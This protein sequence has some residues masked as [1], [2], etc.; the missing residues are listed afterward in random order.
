LKTDSIL[1]GINWEQN[2]TACLMINGEVIACVSEERFSRVKN[3]ERYPINAINWILKHYNINSNEIEAVCVISKL[4][5]P[6]YILTRHYTNFSIENYIEEQ[7]KIWFQR[8]YKKKKISQVKTFEKKL[9]FYQYP[10]PKFWKKVIK[11]IKNTNDHVSNNEMINLGK[12]IRRNVIK[13]HLKIKDDKIKFMD[14]SF[15]HAN[16]AFFSRNYNSKSSLVLSMDAFG[17][18]INYSSRIYT[19]K[20]GKLII[21]K[22]SE[23]NSFIIGRLYRYVTLIL[24][25][26]PNEHEYKVMGLAPYAKDNYAEKVKNVFRKYQTVKGLHFKFLKKP[27]DLYFQVKE[28]LK[29]FRFDNIAAG[30]Q[31]YTEE[32]I[33]KWIRNLLLKKK[34]Y[35]IC[36]AG[37]VAMNVKTNMLISSL[38][39]KIKLYVPP[40]PDDSSQAMGACYTYQVLKYK[41]NCLKYCYPIKNAYLGPD[42]DKKKLNY[43]IKKKI[44]KKKFKI[45]NKNINIYAAKLLAKNKIVGRFCG[46]AEF[47]ARSLGNRS[48][49]ASPSNFDIIKKINEKVKNRDFWMPFAASILQNQSK[50]YFKKKIYSKNYNYMTNCLHTNIKASSDFAAV[51]HPYDK[52]CRPQIISKNQ[53]IE[54]EDLIHKFGEITGIYGILN[55]S[56]NLHG[57]PIVNSTENAMNIFLKTNLDALILENFLIVKK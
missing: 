21:K 19:I 32:L 39:K 43:F 47:G 26:K 9:D 16:F 5:S 10:G 8:I 20:K 23:G 11:K 12:E 54:Y 44:P 38:S 34:I 49:L 6:G 28:D 56:F 37:G 36:L 15:G 46:R 13:K 35:N 24:G 40:S 18:N 4:W 41:E 29:S 48:I 30:L 45:I 1:I 25:F 55:T 51:I 31:S 7:Q 3:D 53:N 42:V 33:L 57:F 52:T 27:K 50:K 14:H 22:L 17:D 2:S